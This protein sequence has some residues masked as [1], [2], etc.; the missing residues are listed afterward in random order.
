MKKKLFILSLILLISGCS[1]VRPSF[2]KGKLQIGDS[3][4]NIEIASTPEQRAY[5]LMFKKHIKD[6]YGMLFVYDK[7]VMPIMWMKNTYV[8]LDMF[9]INSEGIIKQI[10]EQTKPLSLDKIS[11]LY[12]V[13]YVLETKADFANKNHISR[14]DKVTFLKN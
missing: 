5:G 4:I 6:N 7:D 13:R 14:L 3:I 1:G 12:T 11:S 10:E 8:S 2:D 9:F